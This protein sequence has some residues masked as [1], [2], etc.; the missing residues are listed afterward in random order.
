MATGRDQ[1]LQ[2][3]VA[4]LVRGVRIPQAAALFHQVEAG[5]HPGAGKHPGIQPHQHDH[6][7]G[8]GPHRFEGADRERPAAVT[9]AA[10]AGGQGLL[11]HRR[12]HRRLQLQGR[13]PRQLPPALEGVEQAGQFGGRAA[14]IAEEVGQQEP[15][16]VG[17]GGGG[18]G[19]SELPQPMAQP[20]EQVK[21][22]AAE[23]QRSPAGGGRGGGFAAR[24][25]SRGGGEHQPQ[26][27]PVDRPAEGMGGVAAAIAAIEPPAETG[28]LQQFVKA[29]TLL[30]REAEP[31]QEGA[32]GQHPLQTRGRE[33]G[34]PELEQGH[35][36]ATDPP[37]GLLAPVREPPGNGHTGGISV[38]EHGTYQGG[39]PVHLG[40]HHQDVA[41]LE[42]G[43]GGHELQQPV[44]NDLHL[45]EGA[46]AGME[47]QGVVGFAPA[48]RAGEGPCDQLILELVQQKG[49][50]PLR[51]RAGAKEKILLLPRS[52]LHLPSALQQLLEFGPEPAEA[53]L[54]GGGPQQPVGVKGIGQGEGIVEA[55]PASGAAFPEVRTGGEQVEVYRLA[56]AEGLQQPHLHGGQAAQTEEPQG[57]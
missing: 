37:F 28:L 18:R 11:Q 15:Q 2:E 3:H 46:G 45:A 33:P 19:P 4:I 27:Q 39:E 41:G 1:G 9:E 21:P 22:A 50:G 12:R 14:P 16:P 57:L 7:V 54:Q 53:G 26:Q 52:E 31:L 36:R 17:P 43:V 24:R 48:H 34:A 32:A 42:A 25:Q 30:R 29:A 13:F 49:S 5:P 10:A 56:A 20:G 35:Q 55:K 40:G 6:A 47:L 23:L 51:G 44:A 8:D 38:A